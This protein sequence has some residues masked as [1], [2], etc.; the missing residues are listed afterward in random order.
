MAWF[1]YFECLNP[2]LMNN[3]CNARNKLI[4]A[5]IKMFHVRALSY[6]FSKQ[7][8]IRNSLQEEL[9][10]KEILFKNFKYIDIII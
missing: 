10:K 7:L 1:S 4:V 3:I 6:R 5:M 2:D 9:L 8:Y